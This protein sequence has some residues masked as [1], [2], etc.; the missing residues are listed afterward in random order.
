MLPQ[1]E[2]IHEGSFNIIVYNKDGEEIAKRS[3]TIDE[4]TALDD[5]TDN[6]I[7]SKIKRW[8]RW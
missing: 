7:V 3:I 8:Y 5:N 4:F 2:D 6:S 1:I